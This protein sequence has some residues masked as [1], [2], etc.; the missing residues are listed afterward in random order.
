MAGLD[1]EQ[2]NQLLAQL[3]NGGNKRKLP[4]FSSGD[5]N[6][7][8]E[9]KITFG[10][11]T[12]LNN[13][14]EPMAKRQLK[15]AMEGFAATAVAH[16]E[17]TDEMTLQEA[18][19][20]YERK[21]VTPAN[22]AAARQNFLTARQRED[23]TLVAWHTR[24]MALYRRSDPNADHNLSRELRERFIMGLAHPTVKER[25]YDA[26]PANMEQALT[27]ASDKFATIAAAGA[28]R[29][30]VSLAHRMGINNL[31]V[32]GVGGGTFE[33]RRFVNTTLKC[34]ICNSSDHLKRDC[35]KNNGKNNFSG[36]KRIQGGG[37][38]GGRRS[39]GKPFRR[40]ENNN[41]AVA[42][43]R[44]QAIDEQGPDEEQQHEP[45]EHAGRLV[46]AGNA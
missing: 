17:I 32:P 6:G 24:V 35:P 18:L 26:N 29:T 20:A 16:V 40:Q 44:I 9:W 21:F 2:F 36:K 4:S 33:Q 37:N 46:D 1:A 12:A 31:Q 8:L 7:W 11:V 42:P 10:N 38:R 27:V 5:A 41:R 45:A 19:A 43:F 15:A 39:G 22:S 23:E 34:F 30:A 13:W 28:D 3:G 14:G 25:T